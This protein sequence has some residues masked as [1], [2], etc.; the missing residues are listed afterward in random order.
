M[1]VVYGLVVLVR[2][3]DAVLKFSGA[4]VGFGGAGIGLVVLE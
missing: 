2:F 3:G 4:G 1:E